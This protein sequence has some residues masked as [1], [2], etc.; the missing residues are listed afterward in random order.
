MVVLIYICGISVPLSL[1]LFV[2]YVVCFALFMWY[3]I[4]LFCG[5]SVVCLSYSGVL[6]C[7]I[8]VVCLSYSCVISLVCVW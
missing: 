7:G 5:I 8:S 2:I 1:A 6:F 4:G 3:V